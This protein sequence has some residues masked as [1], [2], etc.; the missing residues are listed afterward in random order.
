MTPT[1]SPHRRPCPFPR[2]WLSAW[3]GFL[4]VLF[5][6]PTLVIGWQQRA[7]RR[8]E[9][10]AWEATLNPNTPDPGMPPAEVVD[11]AGARRVSIGF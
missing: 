11:T 9:K 10:H 8:F 1:R 3:V 5:L 6:L 4:V 7:S 2:D